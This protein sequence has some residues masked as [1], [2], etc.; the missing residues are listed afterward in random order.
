MVSFSHASG[1]AA[2][3]VL[4]RE[5]QKQLGQFMTPES[6]ARYMARRCLP[7]ERLQL[8]RVL[9]PA[10]GA[11]ILAAAVVES[12]LES[13]TR[14]EQIQVMLFEL[15][16]RLIPILRDLA[17]RMRR[18]AKNRGVSLTVSI[19]CEDFL[20]SS[21]ALAH[22][23]VADII[24]S[25]PPYF[26]MSAKDPRALAHSYAIHG[27]PNIYGLFMA[28]CA[29]L[30][31]PAGRWCFITPRSWT[32]GSYFAAMRRHIFN[33]LH[34]DAM[35]VFES[36]KDHFT[37]DAV[38]QE[39][40]ITWAT[41]QA[42]PHA[43]VL[44]SSS[45]GSRDIADARLLLLPLH[46]ILGQD[47]MI[48]LP[49]EIPNMMAGWT[50]TLGTYGLKV[51]TGPVVAFRAAKYISEKK[52]AKSVPL[53]WMQHIQH[54][55]INWP[56]N[57]KREHIVASCETAWMLVSNINLVVMRRFSPKEA[58]RR[59]TAAPY[60]AGTL[61]GAVIG[62]EN[63]TNY[64]CRPGGQLTSNEARGL[65]AFLNSRIADH[66]FRTVAGNTQVNATDLR[67]LP[68]PSW[69]SIVAIGRAVRAS[70][71][72]SKVDSVVENFLRTEQPQDAVGGGV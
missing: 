43:E 68:L 5:E 7:S 3:Q 35:H 64:I 13:D 4:S 18:S 52:L 14:P 57:K 40:M 62:L 61:P 63:H 49:T 34:I 1:I 41:A 25:N 27:Q 50:A 19:R 48:A 32:N 21:V 47:E 17:G 59:I 42:H 24:I 2:T 72:L 46:Q 11:G 26:K 6:V 71:S 8:L 23:P 66:Y 15:D 51:S 58:Q 12:L 37:D 44:V 16:E 53:L 54:M 33:W 67:K 69:D 29:T 30:I 45:E 55:Q 38:L 20:L 31:A 28:A 65:A 70:T 22:Q 60:I 10:A 36:R 9:D 39:A 56:I